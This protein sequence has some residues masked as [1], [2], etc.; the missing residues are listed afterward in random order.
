MFMK[1]VLVIPAFNEEKSIVSVIKN[2]PKKINGVSQ[3]IPVVVDD[4]SLD[5]TYNLAKKHLKYVIRHIVNLGV[6]AATTSG[7]EAAKK[8]NADIVVTLDADGQH[9]PSNIKRVIDPILKKQADIVI[10]TRML[11]TKEMPTLKVIG[12]WIMNLITM[13]VFQV[14]TTDSQSGMKALNRRA[15]DK[16]KLHSLGYEVCSEIIG[17]VKRNKLKLKEITIDTIYSDY[18]KSRG[19]SWFNAVNILTRIISIKISGR[20]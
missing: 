17:E 11:D 15:L 6:G 8:L 12:N 9:N 13:L 19:Q 7:F 1:L 18:S 4:G 20:K 3:V 10:G 2:L 5:E 16:I 14:W